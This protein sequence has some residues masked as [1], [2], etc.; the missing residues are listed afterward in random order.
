MSIGKTILKF[1]L[2]FIVIVIILFFA[3]LYTVDEN[4]YKALFQVQLSKMTGLD[5]A[6]DGPLR[7]NLIPLPHIEMKNITLKADLR[8]NKEINAHIKDMSFAM[9]WNTLFEDIKEL[10]NIEASNI[11]IHYIDAQKKLYNLNIDKFSGDIVSTYNN[12]SLPAFKL[13][14]GNIVVNGDISVNTLKETLFVKG[15]VSA[16]EWTSFYSSKQLIA[17]KTLLS[18]SFS[19]DWLN[20]LDATVDFKVDN[21]R[22]KDKVQKDA[23][24]T[25]NLKGRVLTINYKQ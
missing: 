17:N 10:K 18:K 2:S 7:I 5:V 4:K 13:A 11:D 23:L 21:L 25:L 22:L 6:L 8:N 14:L 1:V 16:N 24:F 12:V 9:P 3:M 19:E 20:R 15:N